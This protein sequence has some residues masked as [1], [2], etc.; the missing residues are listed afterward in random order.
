MRILYIDIDSLR[1]DH[2]GC[3]GYHRATSPTI[4][5]VASEGVRFERCHVSDAPCMPSR[6]AMVTGRFGIH[7]GVVAHEGSTADPF[8]IGDNRAFSVTPG[9]EPLP[10]ILQRLGFYTVS[11]SPFPQRHA[12]WWYVGGLRE[13]I[14]TGKNGLDRAEEVTPFALDWLKR[15]AERDNWFLHVN[16][17]DPHTPYRTPLDYG[18]PFK[19]EPPPS[20]FTE[21]VLRA[22]RESF[23]VRGAEE[24]MFP[25]LNPSETWTRMPDQIA[26]LDDYK[27]WIDGYDTAIRYVDDHIRQILDILDEKGVL[28]ETIIIISADHGDNQG[29]LNHFG[30]HHFGD[31]VTTRVPLIVRLPGITDHQKG[32]VDRAL[33]YQFDWWATLIELLGGE[34]PRYWDAQSFAADFRAG[35]EKGR[36]YLVCS[37]MAYVCQRSVH[38]DGW[39]LLRT[40]HPTLY[41]FRPL[42]LYRVSDDPHELNDLSDDRPEIVQRGLALLAEWFDAMMATMTAPNPVDPMRIVL[43]EGGPLLGRRHWREYCEHLRKTRRGHHAETIERRYSK[44]S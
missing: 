37:Q 38:F 15:N 2:L 19:D 42:Q 26:S 22:C 17:W 28:D 6:T 25:R 24:P 32:R 43:R 4:D 35:R 16:F 30:D 12:C 34:I 23:G 33:L 29:E 11:V 44:P 1:P 20:W 21:E 5:W 10:L 8:P 40:Y 7:T 36:P 27:R 13:W 31:F 9:F 14:N 41:D 18:N 39:V 3:Y